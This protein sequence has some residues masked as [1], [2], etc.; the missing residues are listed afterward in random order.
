MPNTVLFEQGEI[1]PHSLT[2]EVILFCLP[3]FCIFYQ[4]SYRS[5]LGNSFDNKEVV[6]YTQ[7][8]HLVQNWSMLI[9]ELPVCPGLKRFYWEINNL[10]SEYPKQA[11]IIDRLNLIKLRSLWSDQTEYSFVLSDRQLGKFLQF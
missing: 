4:G 8:A 9:D 6:Q 7:E 5:V 10:L 2:D 3:E 11:E 1:S